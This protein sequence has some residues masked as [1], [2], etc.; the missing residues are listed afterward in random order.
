MPL[1]VSLVLLIG[2]VWSL[3]PAPPTTAASATSAAAKVS[4]AKA[5]EV[6]TRRC[7]S[8]HA[9][10][11]TQ[12]G[13]AAAPKGV[14]LE[15]LADLDKHARAIHQQTVVTRVMPIGN[16]TQMSAAERALIGRWYAMRR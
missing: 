1:V 8:C 11:P 16:L 7:A 2:L 5:L 15:K 3:A 6:V 10:K 4:D 14:V 12:P 13:F 9:G